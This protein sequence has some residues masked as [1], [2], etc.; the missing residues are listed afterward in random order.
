[1]K[2]TMLFLIALALVSP[3]RADN[4]PYTENMLQAK[5]MT[6]SASGE[7]SLLQAATYF[8]RIAALNPDEWLPHYY[9]S[10]CYARISHLK[11]DAAEKDAWTDKAQVEADK[12]FALDPANAEVL[13]MKGFV[14]Q[15]RMSVDPASRG[16]RYNEETLGYFK[17]ALEL[18]PENPRAY[19]WLG[20]NILNTPEMF[21]G[22]AAAACPLL[23]AAMVKFG[24]FVPGPLAPD[25][26]YSYAREI[27]ENCK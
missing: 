4:D 20:V 6:D 17:K 11:S 7:T 25:W 9:A 13:V 1:M 23:Q 5:A 12:A 27:M 14:L 2:K 22:G 21:G 19:L 24:V 10:Y 3:G 8:E 16:Y 18:D 26:G 15:A